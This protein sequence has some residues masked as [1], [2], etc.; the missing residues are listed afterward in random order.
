MSFILLYRKMLATEWILRDCNGYICRFISICDDARCC[1]VTLVYKITKVHCL[2]SAFM[3]GK[4][5][6]CVL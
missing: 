5:G 1:W 2:Q 4:Q 6:I 3:Q